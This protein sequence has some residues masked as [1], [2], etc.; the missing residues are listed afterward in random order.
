M[1]KLA[2]GR[3]VYI[4]ISLISIFSYGCYYDVEEELYPN[5]NDKNCDTTAVSYSTV[6]KPILDAKCNT[7]HG[8]NATSGG[9]IKLGGYE[10]LSA[11]LNASKNSFISS[12]NHDGNASSMPKGQPKLPECEINKLKAW[13][14][15]GYLQN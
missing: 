5:G 14:N 1:S 8:G 15:Q 13:I 6:I 3:K 12:I 7:C 10:D 4:V 9:E 11:F 2:Q